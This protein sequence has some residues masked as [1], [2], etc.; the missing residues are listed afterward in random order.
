MYSWK[1]YLSA[2]V[3][4]T[5]NDNN[6]N[7]GGKGVKIQPILS[8]VTRNCMLYQWW[9]ANKMLHVESCWEK[10]SWREIYPLDPQP[11]RHS[12]LVP[13][14]CAPRVIRCCLGKNWSHDFFSA[15]SQSCGT[16]VIYD[17][18]SRRQRNLMTHAQCPLPVY[19]SQV[20]VKFQQSDQK[21][22]L[23]F[24]KFISGFG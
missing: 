13:R 23:T 10:C 6:I 9:P 5:L 1:G 24:L 19:Y 17:S 16:Q 20:H 11:H 8:L 15:G 21:T 2:P 18:Y 3:K 22:I 12:M 4:W 14:W 7:G